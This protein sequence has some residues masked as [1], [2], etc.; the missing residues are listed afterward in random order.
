MDVG[1]TARRL[2]DVHVPDD[3]AE[4]G[5]TQTV[6]HQERGKSICLLSAIGKLFEKL[7]MLRLTDTALAPDRISD[8]QFGFMP[9]RSTEDAIVELRQMVS[10]AED[11][12]VVALLFDISRA[13]DNVWW[14]LVFQA[15]KER[16]CPRNVFG[17]LQSFKDRQ[18]VISSGE[19]A[20]SKRATRRCPQGSVFGPGG[21]NLMFDGLLKVLDNVVKDQYIAYADDLLVLVTGSFRR[22]IEVKGQRV[23]NEISEW[24]RMAKLQI[25]EQKTEAIL[26][27]SKEI[28]RAQTTA[29]PGRVRQGR[30]KLVGFESRPPIIRLG[31][32][33]IKFKD[34][35]RY[36]GVH[37]D[38]GMKDEDVAILIDCIEQL[39]TTNVESPHTS[40]SANNSDNVMTH[41]DAVTNHD[42]TTVLLEGCGWMW[43]E[44]LLLPQ[45]SSLKAKQ[46]NENIIDITQDINLVKPA[47]ISNVN[48]NNDNDISTIQT[49]SGRTL[50]QKSN[51]D[52]ATEKEEEEEEQEEERNMMLQNDQERAE[53]VERAD[54]QN[55]RDRVE[56]KTF[57]I[58]RENRRY[59][60]R[61]DA[62]GREITIAVRQPTE[63]LNPLIWLDEVFAEIHAYLTGSCNPDDYI[64]VTFTADAFAHGPVWLS[65]RYV[66]DLQYIDLW[67]LVNRAAQSAT[68]FCI[69]DSCTLTCCII[70]HMSGGSRRKLTHDNVAKRSILTITN[71][72]NLCLPRSLVA[73]RAYVERGEIRSGELHRRWM[74]IRL[75]R[76]KLQKEAAL[77]LVRN[78]KIDIPSGGCSVAE[79]KHFQKYL[80]NVGIAIVVYEVD[81]LG[82]GGAALYDGTDYGQGV[83]PGGTQMGRPPVVPVGVSRAPWALA[84]D[85]RFT[86]KLLI[87]R[88]R[89]VQALLDFSIATLGAVGFAKIVDGIMLRM[90]VRARKHVGGHL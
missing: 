62:H 72:D 30:K 79:L 44:F 4:E 48:K 21:W 7:L 85:A 16:E 24:C 27:R 43:D 34:S 54:V 8:R 35:V 49:G 74:S 63:D 82:R 53:E 81:T 36:L 40:T 55:D 12:Y 41:A 87:L 86:A 37:F 33:K 65:Y 58:S 77:E 31:S 90:P 39:E 89:T 56:P 5:H 10:R 50:L 20:I 1:E 84:R 11:G 57:D 22:E 73:A 66:R 17:V 45:R 32:S 61:F 80:A 60:P 2:L 69:N 64:G 51:R 76:G 71:T 6:R 52:T 9:G 83:R 13:F 29:R 3:R 78:A 47:S 18:V 75:S 70:R 88:K 42:N 28:R 14:P 38:K 59:F 15:L 46:D 23:V 25:S 68:D 19:I 26:L 67:E